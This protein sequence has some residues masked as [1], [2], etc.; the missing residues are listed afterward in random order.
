MAIFIIQFFI[1]TQVS[2]VNENIFNI[3]ERKIAVICSTAISNIY[4]IHI[5]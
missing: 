2:L 4:Y 5:S 1:S 3:L